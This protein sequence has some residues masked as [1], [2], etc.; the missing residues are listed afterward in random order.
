MAREGQDK[1]LELC[2]SDFSWSNPHPSV[3]LA[4]TV[5]GRELHRGWRTRS[6]RWVHSQFPVPTLQYVRATNKQGSIR[7]NNAKKACLSR[8]TPF[9]GTGGI[10]CFS[11]LESHRRHLHRSYLTERGGKTGREEPL[12]HPRQLLVKNVPESLSPD[13]LS[14]RDHQL[15]SWGPSTGL[16]WKQLQ[17]KASVL[18]M[19]TLAKHWTHS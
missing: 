16:L 4:R 17:I 5:Q 6:P 13:F 15:I 11:R 1:C 12:R 19:L 14:P 8:L 2:H 7:V 18:D 9:K 3:T 10:T